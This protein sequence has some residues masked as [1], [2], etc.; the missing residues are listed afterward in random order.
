MLPQKQT[1]DIFDG[2]VRLPNFISPKVIKFD[3]LLTALIPN[4]VGK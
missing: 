4:I 1:W 3:F 2:I